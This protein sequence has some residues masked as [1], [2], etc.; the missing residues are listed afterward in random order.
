[1]TENNKF[2]KHVFE[3]RNNYNTTTKSMTP[4]NR[5]HL[6]LHICVRLLILDILLISIH[7]NKLIQY[8][9][10]ILKKNKSS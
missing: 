7:P 3:L 4:L 1:M 10:S 9:Y 2:G 8:S 5:P 6:G